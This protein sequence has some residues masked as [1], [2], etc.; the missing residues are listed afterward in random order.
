MTAQTTMTDCC[1]AADQLDKR[2]QNYTALSD[3]Y[4][5]ADSYRVLS[6]MPGTSREAITISLLDSTL[7]IDA[8]VADRTI[9]RGRMCRREYGVGD[10][11]RTFR[12]GGGIEGD[13]IEATYRQGVLEVTLPK[14][15]PLKPRQVEVRNG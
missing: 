6:D 7:T 15:E 11:H 3:V 8:S 13:A 14:A 10:F 1:G 9:G 5:T 2:P 12:V 4:E